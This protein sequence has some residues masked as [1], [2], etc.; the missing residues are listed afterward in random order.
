MNWTR[1]LPLR[2]IIR[3]AARSQ[4]FLD[5]IELLARLRSFAQPSEVGE[6]VELLRAGA[7]FHARGLINS[8]IIQH[9]LDWI[10]PY[11]IVRQYDPADDSFLPRAFSIS[12]I[13]LTN[14]NWTALGYPDCD[15]LPLVDPRGMLTPFFDGWSLDCWLLTEDGDTLLPSKTIS[16]EQIQKMEDTLSIM[17]RTGHEGLTINTEA[18]VELEH[19]VPMCR[20][21][22]FWLMRTQ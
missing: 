4:G 19:G 14:R 22:R 20:L 5:P 18:S 1:W 10:W 16:A 2:F 7:I 15:Q 21:S 6:P 13:N 8:K 9:N 17:T 11:W 12:H 3:R